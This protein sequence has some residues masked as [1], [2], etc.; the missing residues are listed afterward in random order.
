MENALNMEKKYD[1]MSADKL[2][3]VTLAILNALVAEELANDLAVGS[4]NK[5]AGFDREKKAKK[6]PKIV[7][8]PLFTLGTNGSI[9]YGSPQDESDHERES[10]ER[11][12]RSLG[13]KIRKGARLA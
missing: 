9:K 10:R 2:S 4:P 3:E 6:T 13:R 5:I 8:L 12:W 1:A 7:Q 11:F